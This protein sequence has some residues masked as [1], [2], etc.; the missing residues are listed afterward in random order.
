MRDHGGKDRG[1]PGPD[2]GGETTARPGAQTLTERLDGVEASAGPYRPPDPAVVAVPV[3]PAERTQG[4]P[5]AASGHTIR[6]VDEL[7]PAERQREAQA[8]AANDMVFGKLRPVLTKQVRSKPADGDADPDS[9]PDPD[10]ES[11]PD[12]DPES[13]PD[14]EALPVPASAR[15][16][17]T[18]HD[19][20]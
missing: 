20:G 10:P 11:A 16:P 14:P 1:A 3:A 15:A 13:A 2:R 18:G 6:F 9:A 8:E 4:Q 12:P 17:V 5:P 19:P 7:A